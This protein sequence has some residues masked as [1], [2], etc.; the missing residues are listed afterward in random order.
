MHKRF[1]SNICEVNTVVA[2]HGS[3]GL[4]SIERG[5]GIGNVSDIV[6]QPAKR[7]HAHIYRSINPVC[8]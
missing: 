5:G 7:I 6:E 8:L 4:L 3:I 2:K 1:F